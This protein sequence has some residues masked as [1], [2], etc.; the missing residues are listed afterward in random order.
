MS[1][2]RLS[3]DKLRPACTN[4]VFVRV[5]HSRNNNTETHKKSIMTY[6]T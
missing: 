1:A 2:Q 4:Y 5:S 6:D 3:Y